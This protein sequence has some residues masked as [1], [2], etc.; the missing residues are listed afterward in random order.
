M[1][2]MRIPIAVGIL[3][4]ALGA[5]SASA[6]T[7]PYLVKDIDASG[8]SNPQE[9]TARGSTLFFT[10][11]GGGKGRELYRSDG[12]SGGTVRV[13]DIRPGSA[14]SHPRELTVAGAR[15]FFAAN[16]GSTGLELYVSDGTSAGTK[17]LTDINPGSTR[18]DIWDLTNVRGTL[19]FFAY[20]A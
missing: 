6:A 12:T 16:D 7:G 20:D 3:A 5:T 15:L 18:S 19:F 2:R 8:S 9:L 17:R 11:T 14:G 13:K 10:A 4:A 1:K